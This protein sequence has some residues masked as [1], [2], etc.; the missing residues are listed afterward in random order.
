M[1]VRRWSATEGKIM[2]QVGSYTFLQVL[3]LAAEDF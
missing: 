3:S 1:L 2:A